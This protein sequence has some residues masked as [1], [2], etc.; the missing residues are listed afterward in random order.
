MNRLN[1]ILTAIVIVFA[2]INYGNSSVNVVKGIFFRVDQS[3]PQ[4]ITGDILSTGQPR[5]DSTWHAFGGFVDQNYTLPLNDWT[6]VTNVAHNLFTGTEGNG[7]TL[8][9]DI[10]TVVNTGDYTGNISLTFSGING[11]DYCIRVW[12]ITQN[13]QM[14][15]KQC[16]S[17][18]S[19]SNFVN[20]SM[21][22]YLEC[23]AGDQLRLEMDEPSN[24]SPILLDC[25]FYINYIHE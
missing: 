1:K 9:G 13:I 15:F 17:T 10:I 7:L 8:S 21:P 18:L 6:W 3:T 23:N 2:I 5:P 20:L 4:K 11:K 16:A 25:M 12:N 24:S 22:L 19:T 14:G